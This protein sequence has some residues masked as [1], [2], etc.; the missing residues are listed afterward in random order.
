MFASPPVS[1]ASVVASLESLRLGER[2]TVVDTEEK[3]RRARG[4]DALLVG[5]AALSVAMPFLLPLDAT[6][7]LP[8]S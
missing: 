4:D 1:A 2:G 7:E 6:S 8:E 5:R 3:D